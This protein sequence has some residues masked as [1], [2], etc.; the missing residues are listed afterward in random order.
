MKLESRS[1]R[2][3]L[4]ID[5]GTSV[6]GYGLLKERGNEIS[7][8][9]LGIVKMDH[10][11]N[12]ALK[13][14][15]IFNK[16]TEIIKAYQPDCIALE[17]PFFGKNVQSMLKLGRA[18]GVAIAAALSKNLPVTEYSPKKIKMSITGNGNA[19]KEQVAAMLQQILGLTNDHEFLD[20]QVVVGVRAAVDDVHHRHR[21]LHRA[22]AAEV[23]VERQA[24]F[25][26]S[27]RC[28]HWSHASVPASGRPPART[29]TGER[30]SSRSGSS[31]S[32]SSCSAHGGWVRGRRVRR[33]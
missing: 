4:G 29:S 19:S 11:K 27:G 18:Q 28:F 8:I 32:A 2:I 17:A 23:T 10:L 31:H 3:I 12:Q 5:P 9:T 26:C 14:Q 15:C 24:G 22:R 13:L 20:V 16:T 21:H 7:L 25:F 6:M 30:R 1:E 33:L